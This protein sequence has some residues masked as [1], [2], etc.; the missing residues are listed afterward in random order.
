MK[1]E[2]IRPAALL[3]KLKRANPPILLD[4]RDIFEFQSWHIPGSINIPMIDLEQK[5]SS[6]D[7]D[8][9]IITICNHGVSSKGVAEMLSG[10]GYHAKYLK[11]GLKGWNTL[12]EIIPV[13]PFVP[14]LL[15][16]FQVKRLGKGCLSYIVVL[17][18][19]KRAI[20]IDPSKHVAQYTKYLDKNNLALVA[21]IDT[22]IH[23]DHI[24]GARI[25][26]EKTSAPYLLPKKSIALFPFHSLEDTLGDII[27]EET[28]IV[29]TPGHTKESV[30]IILG[31]S[32]LFTGDTLFIESVGRSDLGQDVKA[33]A[34][35]LFHS[36]IDKIFTLDEAL[37]VLP[38]HN[39]KTMLPGEP[40]YTAK[41]LNIKEKNDIHKFA[42]DEEFADF[43]HGHPSPTPPNY[44]KIKEINKSGKLSNMDQDELELGGN[45]CSVSL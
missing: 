13:K 10:K 44:S 24:S 1:N 32:F 14:S 7:K 34:K 21:V 35:I 15:E 22:H 23:A 11:D 37:L 12:Y 18:D 16:V 25:L 45:R 2:T 36:V 28:I 42:T 27:G 40:A 19:K 20:V 43:I 9:E 5:I 26:A 41:L 31:K 39:Q 6:L 3:Q 33:N 17:S 29:E 8:R 4:V 38:V 30:C